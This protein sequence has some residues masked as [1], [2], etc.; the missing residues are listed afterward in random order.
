MLLAANPHTQML[1]PQLVG[2]HAG[3]EKGYADPNLPRKSFLGLEIWYLRTRTLCLK[4]VNETVK[5]LNASMI[6]TIT[7]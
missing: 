2:V 5:S 7:P 6:P 3:L 1:S 4:D